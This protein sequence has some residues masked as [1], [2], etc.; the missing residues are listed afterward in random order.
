MKIYSLL[1]FLFISSE[2]FGQC[3]PEL[4]YQIPTTTLTCFNPTVIAFGTTTS[5][6][7]FIQWYQPSI[8]TLVNSHSIIIGY[9]SGGI[10]PPFPP[11]PPYDSYTVIATN[12][13]LNCSTTVIVNIYKNFKPP[14]SIPK[15]I[16]SNSIICQNNSV[17]LGPGNS[18]VTSGIPGA[19]L[20]N[21]FWESPSGTFTNAVNFN[22]TTAGTHSLT[23]T[24]SYNG[25]KSTG[26]V[27]VTDSRPQFN[28]QGM[29][30][31]TSV[32]CNGSVTINTQIPNGYSLSTTS[33]SLNGTT[34]NNLCY[35][36]VKVCMTLTNSQCF[37]CDSLLIN[38]ATSIDENDWKKEV[39]IF[40]NP[41]NGNLN[42]TYP[43]RE[44]TKIKIFDLEGKMILVD[45]NINT[46]ASFTKTEALKVSVTNTSSN[47]LEIKD[48]K[49]GVYM[50]EL[51]V[52][53]SILRKKIIVLK[54]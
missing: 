24:D 33:G 28:L 43:L 23:V 2:I 15:V 41:S 9:P 22:A 32:S 37:K 45:P 51:N 35:G 13:L 46:G 10:N 39:L 8:P 54:P 48:L 44:K 27:L 42:I 52:D 5:S 19:T 3:P 49:A 7:T 14:I 47:K 36:W 25:C 31:T 30:P 11:P 38:A 18:T 29:A 21:S 6:N 4:D 50:V 40:P 12:T 16:D 17:L 53:E 1:I 34:I 20:I 26:T